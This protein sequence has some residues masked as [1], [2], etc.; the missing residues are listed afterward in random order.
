MLTDVVRDADITGMS[1]EPGLFI[2]GAAKSTS[3]L[4]RNVGVPW[5]CMIGDS[6]ILLENGS[7]RILP[8]AA[9]LAAEQPWCLCVGSLLTCAL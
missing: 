9:A 1:Q 3:K 6:F 2:P 5:G 8:P 7:R 4:C